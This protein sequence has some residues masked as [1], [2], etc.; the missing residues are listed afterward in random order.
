MPVI[1]H[2]PL[3]LQTGHFI[4]EVNSGHSNGKALCGKALRLLFSVARSSPTFSLK[5]FKCLLWFSCTKRFFIQC[6][7]AV[8]R[9]ESRAAVSA[10]VF[11]CNVFLVVAVLLCAVLLCDRVVKPSCKDVTIVARF[12][13]LDH[14]G[15][16]RWAKAE[17]YRNTSD[18]Q[19][20]H[21]LC[22]RLRRNG[23]GGKCAGVCV[24][25]SRFL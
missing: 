1:L 20:E 11:Q 14:H 17:P 22:K 25:S 19:W 4:A 7:A 6:S 21:E 8:G 16:P 5:T 3:L 23:S 12:G 9:A 10:A 24:R 18:S 13:L 2:C 15:T